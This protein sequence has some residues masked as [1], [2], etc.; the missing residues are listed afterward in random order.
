MPTNQY[1]TQENLKETL[2][3]LLKLIKL[4]ELQNTVSRSFC[5]Q[6]QKQK[7]LFTDGGSDLSKPI[8]LVTYSMCFFKRPILSFQFRS[9]PENISQRF[10]LQIQF[11][12]NAAFQYQYHN[13]IS[14][15][16]FSHLAIDFFPVVPQK[17][18][19]YRSFSQELHV[20]NM[21]TNTYRLTIFTSYFVALQDLKK[22]SLNV[23]GSSF[24]SW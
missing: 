1:R 18:F 3:K 8:P 9:F 7:I 2:K 12:S 6:T 23:L 4:E 22:K 11:M 20:G 13:L 21:A 5:I 14:L 24:Y 10:L 19:L 17:I 15:N 16:A